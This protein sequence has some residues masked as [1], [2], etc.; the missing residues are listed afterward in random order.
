[1]GGGWGNTINWSGN[2]QF[3][4]KQLTEKSRFSCHGWKLKKPKVGDHLKAEFERSWITFEFV[5]VKPCGDPPDMFFAEV[6]PI[7]QEMK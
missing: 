7:K 2:E 5:E 6:R 3:Q 4:K 1:M